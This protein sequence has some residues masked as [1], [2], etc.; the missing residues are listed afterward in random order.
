MSG[1]EVRSLRATVL[2]KNTEQTAHL[3]AWRHG[4]GVGGFTHPMD[5]VML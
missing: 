1:F 3:A 5:T 4:D 2:L